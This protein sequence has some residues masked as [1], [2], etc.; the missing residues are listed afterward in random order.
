MGHI[1]G[2]LVNPFP[3]RYFLAISLK[4]IVKRHHGENQSNTFFV[5]SQPVIRIQD[6]YDLEGKVASTKTFV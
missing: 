3:P 5:C 4:S 6:A 2:I 1:F